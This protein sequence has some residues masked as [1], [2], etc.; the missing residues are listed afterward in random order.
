MAKGEWS[1]TLMI[2]GM[3][4]CYISNESFELYLKIDDKLSVFNGKVSCVWE[5]NHRGSAWRC[6][7]HHLHHDDLS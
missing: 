6:Y 5:S 2:H 7:I 3:N 1:E 4:K